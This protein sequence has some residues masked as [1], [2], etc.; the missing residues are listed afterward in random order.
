MF[1][2]C[3]GRLFGAGKEKKKFGRVR[4]NERMRSQFQFNVDEL[5]EWVGGRWWKNENEMSK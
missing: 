1:T 4:M 3:Y 5:V 2:S